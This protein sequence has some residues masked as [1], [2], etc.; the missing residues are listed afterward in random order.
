M[1]TAEVETGMRLLESAEA[2]E[3]EVLSSLGWV[4]VEFM[5]DGCAA[6]TSLDLVLT[7]VSARENMVK[8]VKLNAHRAPDVA[9]RYG[10]QTVPVM[11]LFK[12]GVEKDCQFGFQSKSKIESWLLER[13]G[14]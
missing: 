14:V 10:I 8:F 1:L 2:F 9:A 4:L 11:M 3:L 13:I 6:C 7:Q 12:D 5:G